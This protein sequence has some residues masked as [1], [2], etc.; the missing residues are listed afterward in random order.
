MNSSLTAAFRLVA[1]P[2]HLQKKHSVAGRCSDSAGCLG[3]RLDE[4]DDRPEEHKQAD[5]QL[6]HKMVVGRR[7]LLQDL[8]LL[9]LD[10][11][12]LEESLAVRQ[13]LELP[14]QHHDL[15]QCPYLECQARYRHPFHLLLYQLLIARYIAVTVPSRVAVWPLPAHGAVLPLLEAGAPK[16]GHDLLARRWDFEEVLLQ[17]AWAW[18]M[19]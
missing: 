10:Y 3:L 11:C 5:L 7:R 8:T 9:F 6:V 15:D 17:N 19:G 14:A 1:G 4:Q 2:Q 12:V 16:Q 18:T 13:Q